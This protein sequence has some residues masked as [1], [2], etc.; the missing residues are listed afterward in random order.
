MKLSIITSTVFLLISLGASR[1]VTTKEDIS[2]RIIDLNAGAKF[3]PAAMM[4]LLIRQG[5]RPTSA[6]AA[7]IRRSRI[8][9]TRITE[10]GSAFTIP[11]TAG[12]K[13]SARLKG[14]VRFQANLANTI[15]TQI[16]NRASNASTRLQSFYEK[17]EKTFRASAKA[18]YFCF[19]QASADYGYSNTEE[20]RDVIS[21]NEFASFAED[22]KDYFEGTESQKLEASYDSEYSGVSPGSRRAEVVK[23]FAYIS[24]NQLTMANGQVLNV[25]QD[26][27][28][29]VITNEDKEVLDRQGP[30]NVEIKLET[31]S[32]LESDT[33]LARPLMN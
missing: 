33:T 12:A 7:G 26:N 11:A 21:S 15:E 13:Y 30:G 3:V 14:S 8:G 9:F 1:P 32:D 18:R 20:T 28:E 25:V 31:L 29:L 6:Q 4:P 24:V 22:T 17:E 16:R 27:P 10:S 23:A 2:D 5:L 19:F